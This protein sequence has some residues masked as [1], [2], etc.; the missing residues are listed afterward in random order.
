[1]KT[2]VIEEGNNSCNGL[3]LRPAFRPYQLFVEPFFNESCKYLINPE[4]QLDWNKF[5]RIG[6]TNHEKDSFGFGWR[7]NPDLNTWEICI[8]M[9]KNW[10]RETITMFRVEDGSVPNMRAI[11]DYNAHRIGIDGY[12]VK[13]DVTIRDYHSVI[14]FRFPKF[15]G[16]TGM[17]YYTDPVYFGGN[18]ITLGNIDT[19]AP[20]RIEIGINHS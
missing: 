14:N 1:M 19:P 9:R 2:Y 8:Y 5:Y 18:N 17:G 11:F 13:D 7:W 4:D 6:F 15:L 16:V 3:N 12:V 20:H 10:E